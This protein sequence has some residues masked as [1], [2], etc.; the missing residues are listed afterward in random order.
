MAPVCYV[1]DDIALEVQETWDDVRLL[2]RCHLLDK[3]SMDVSGVRQRP[4][5]IVQQLCFL[6]TETEVLEKFQ[7]LQSKTVLGLL[8]KKQ[9]CCPG[10]E[11]GFQR[12]AVGFQAVCPAFCAMLAEDIHVLNGIVEPHC[13]LR[14]VN[15]AYLC[16]LAQELDLLMEKEL[17][18]IL[19]DNSTQGGKGMRSSCKKAAVGQCISTSLCKC[20]IGYI[21]CKQVWRET[22]HEKGLGSCI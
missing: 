6:Y 20:V 22:W 3:L 10:R 15:Q 8:R 9:T 13:I 14:F 12:L 18:V 4:V 7:A 1:H 11:S 16:M 21:M 5:Y 2:L 19:K 17:E